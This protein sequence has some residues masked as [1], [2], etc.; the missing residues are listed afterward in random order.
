MSKPAYVSYSDADFLVEFSNDMDRLCP[1]PGADDGRLALSY[2]PVQYDFRSCVV[3]T[4]I[5]R[6]VIDSSH[7]EDTSLYKLENLHKFMPPK[8]QVLDDTQQSA[9]AVALYEI[10]LRFHSLY[11]KLIH[12][13]LLPA[14]QVEDVY[15]QVTPTFRVF[16]A[17]SKG[18][19]GKTSYHNDIMLGHNP[20]E[21]NV[22]LPLTSCE[23]SR[24][25]L[26]APLSKSLDL[27]RP[28]HN[29]YAR[30]AED[31]QS[32]DD[33]QQRCESICSPL[34]MEVGEILVFDSRCIHAGPE[35]RTEKS[36]VTVDF[37]LLPKSHIERQSNIYRG[38][39]RMK[40]LFAPGGAFSEKT[41]RTR[42]CDE[43]GVFERA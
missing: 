23:A 13:V 6:G 41:I 39:G 11:E 4:L 24:S 36:R 2:D 26:L 5:E 22:F 15:W 12:D 32:S 28:Y 9:V 19:P 37:R 1:L 38:T 7:R 34:K 25:L 30:F 31:V 42:L 43:A 27:L 14:L 35:N 16:F 18:Y 17:D 21:I 10:N 40:A 8:D 20:R 29:D 33:V 3:D